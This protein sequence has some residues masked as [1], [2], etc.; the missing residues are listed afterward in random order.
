MK[1]LCLNNDSIKRKFYQNR[2]I[3][4]CAKIPESRNFRVFVICRR[5]SK[6]NKISTWMIQ[7]VRSQV[8]PLITGSRRSIAEFS[9]VAQ[10]TRSAEANKN[11]PMLST[12]RTIFNNV[13]G[14]PFSPLRNSP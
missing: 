8:K 14:I 2:F 12:V 1:N 3:N 5:T 4:E 9:L 6:L 10:Y 13:W 7:T 11:R